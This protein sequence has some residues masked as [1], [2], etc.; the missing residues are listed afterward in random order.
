MPVSEPR[1]SSSV[2]AETCP[3]MIGYG[4]PDEP[5]VPQVDVGAA[6]FGT[7]GAQQRGSRAVDRTGKLAHLDRLPRRG[8]HGGEDAITHAVRYP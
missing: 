8:H 1:T 7:R 5:S 6:H 3:G 4:T 2:P